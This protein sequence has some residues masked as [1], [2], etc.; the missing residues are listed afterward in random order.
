VP[1]AGRRPGRPRRPPVVVVGGG[2][3]GLATAWSLRHDAEVTVVEASDRLGGKIRTV[4]LPGAGVDV[5]AG[6]DTFLAR[7]PHA[8]RLCRDLGLGGDLV[9]PATGKAFV[10]T[11]GALHAL[12][13]DHVLGVPVDLL[14]LA[15]SG[16]LPPAAVARAAL[17]LVLPRTRLPEDPTVA[18]V[19]GRRMGAG[20]LDRLVEPLI[21][22]INAGRADDL[23]L[24]ATAP[25]LAAAAAA[26]RSLV[27]GLRRH[28]RD[29]PP[30]S[31]GPL[32]LGI[33]GGM[34]RLVDRLQSELR[35]AGVCVLTGTA[36]TAIEPAGANYRV[37]TTGRAA[38]GPTAVGPAP[39][40]PT[41]GEAGNA[42]AEADAVVITVP[43]YAAAPLLPPAAGDLAAI[44][45]ASVAV[46]TLAYRPDSFPASL[47]G[48]GFLVPRV[49]G[50]L[51]T[52]CT[53]TTSKWPPPAG[54][55][56]V[57]LR[58]SAGRAGDDRPDHLGDAE[59]VAR[60]HD[61]LHEAIGVTGPPAAS[62][63]TRWANGFPQYQ[64]GHQ[65]RVDRIDAT[66]AAELP[67]V[68]VAGAAYR[69]LGIAA[70]VRQAE[71]AA[72]KV[73]SR[74]AGAAAAAVTAGSPP[75]SGRP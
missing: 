33:A 9:E 34:H 1:E 57:L 16:L 11:G 62:L 30:A 59:L 10:W 71:E 35:A 3:T 2:I 36:A 46:T 18:D 5:E 14:A 70:C 55:E 74:L 24:A 51:M 68:F 32:F 20:V 64:P 73:R 13:R 45:Y 28:R 47:D 17:D 31:D 52:A 60:L 26:S 37:A 61:E 69:G 15:R 44:A 38:V 29:T 67:G 23:S 39:V 4:E 43:A 49:D 75:P 63:V 7:A 48:A 21:G 12:P 65:R 56:L 72:A 19:V 58:A 22:G 8:T 27:L 53:F 42:V 41:A 25:Q 50:R 66:L 54:A 6:P 40:G